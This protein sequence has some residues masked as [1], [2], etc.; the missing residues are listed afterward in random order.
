M[1]TKAFFNDEPTAVESALLP[2]GKLEVWLRKNIR[3]AEDPDTGERIYIADEAYMRTGASIGDVLAAQDE[4]FERASLWKPEP[5]AEPPHRSIAERI[6]SLERANAQLD[7]RL[8][9]TM[10]AVDYLLFSEIE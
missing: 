1:R 6:K 2:D 7:E 8:R 5:G 3:A 4:F 10:D 9:N